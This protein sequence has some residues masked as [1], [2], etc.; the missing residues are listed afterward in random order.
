MREKQ[1]SAPGEAR[2]PGPSFKDF[3][4]KDQSQPPAAFLEES[5]E[6]L[7]D[8]DIPYSHYTSTEYADKEGE[9]LWPRTWQWACRE[10][11]IPEPGDYYVYDVA[12]LSAIILRTESGEIKGFFNACMHRGTQ[13]K[14]P[15]SCGYSKDLRC[16]FHGW[17]YSLDGELIHLP[18]QWDFPHV[19][20]DSH[21][22][23]EVSVDTWAGF[24]FVNFDQNASSLEEYLGVMPQH[25]ADFKIENRYV[26]LHIQKRLPCNW[27]AAAEAFLEAY[28]VPETHAG[29]MDGTE[30]ATQY[31][32]FGE[33][34]SRF[35]HTVGAPCP[36]TDPPPSEQ[37]LL[38]SLFVRGSEDEEVP[39]VPEGMTARDVYAEIVRTQFAET[40]E[41]DFSHI[42]TSQVLDSIEYFLFPNM[43]LFPGLSLPMVYRFRPDP[44]DPDYSLF[45]LL[46]LRPNPLEGPA[47]LPPEPVFVD[48]EESYANVPGIGRLG[49]VYDQ[50]TNNL[51]AQTRGFKSSLKRGETLGNY[52]EIRARHL[53][54]RVEHFIND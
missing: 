45:D 28:H 44:K 3:I 9:K 42:S 27:K 22:L 36:L 53:H 38:E 47:P 37:K 10:D 20:K 25:F 43:F 52:Q 30:V 6:F 31:D 51:A 29:G 8:Q 32:V 50:D 15:G 4:L 23:P 13:L 33:N 26:D 34:V 21:N 5:Y 17:I 24:V 7:G 48:I 46:F 11:H 16:P 1:Q 40:Y 12:D 18:Q 14:E 41:Q 19:E 54:S 2:L 49:F 35:I 39:V